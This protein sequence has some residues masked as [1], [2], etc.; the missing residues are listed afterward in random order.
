MRLLGQ[1]GFLTNGLMIGIVLLLMDDPGLD[2]MA[3]TPSVDP[4][5]AEVDDRR[6]ERPTIAP[7][8]KRRLPGKTKGV[9]IGMS[10][11]K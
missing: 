8:D 9:Q 3:E 6:A 10:E 4:P 1:L 2:P 11:Y 7:T 5:P